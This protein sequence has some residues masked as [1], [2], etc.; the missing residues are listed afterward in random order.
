MSAMID[1]I[2]NKSNASMYLADL[3]EN[4]LDNPLL[5][6]QFNSEG[7][8]ELIPF[9]FTSDINKASLIVVQSD[10]WNWRNNKEYLSY[11]K[12][13]SLKKPLLVTNSSDFFTKRPIQNAIYLRY[14]L[15]PGEGAKNTIVVPFPIKPV[16]AARSIN[17]D[18]SVSFSG[19]VPDRFIV[20]F[21]RTAMNSPLHPIK[22]NGAI[23]RNLMIHKM[24]KTNL[25]LRL[26]ILSN[27]S[28]HYFRFEKLSSDLY[29]SYVESIT[30][31][32]YVLCPRGDAN[33]SQRFFE[34]LSAGRIPV[35]I[36]S[37]IV[38]PK[39]DLPYFNKV[40]L[41]LNIFESAKSWERKIRQ[42]NNK[43]YSDE[44]FVEISKK[45]HHIYESELSYYAFISK[46]FKNFLLK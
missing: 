3:F 45:I 7:R 30:N 11:L 2:L 18:F 4:P 44:K 12:N 13:L 22:G 29:N 40:F 31:S 43:I 20:R 37:N 38:F 28:G 33:Q 35:L 25:E 8:K 9:N 26:K 34:V 32:R 21:F 27:Y 14:A 10:I 41:N 15:N 24:K 42:F 6:R 39:N 16:Y 23:V 46:I 17:P 19:Y 5:H 36:N 1:N